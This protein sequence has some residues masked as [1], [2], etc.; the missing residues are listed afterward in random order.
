MN[1][2]QRLFGRVERAGSE[3]GARIVFMSVALW[4]G[5]YNY[6]NLSGG[7]LTDRYHRDDRDKNVESQSRFA[8]NRW[9]G[10][11][12]QDKIFGMIGISIP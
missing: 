1:R 11:N 5:F 6:N 3:C 7:Y 12:V 8:P 4:S 2:A 10:K 9:Q